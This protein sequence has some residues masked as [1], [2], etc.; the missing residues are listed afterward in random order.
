MPSE[1]QVS[2][3][4]PVFNAENFIDR[5][6]A[7][8][9]SQTEICW[10]LIAID[11]GSTDNSGHKLDTWAMKDARIKVYHQTNSG[12]AATRQKGV[13][14]A[15]GEY[16][17][18]VDA[19][20]WVEPDF[21]QVLLA[22]AKSTGADIVW[23]DCFTNESDQ[24]TMPCDPSPRAMIRA[25]LE[26]QMWGMLWNKLIRTSICQRQ[27]VVFPKDCSMW[28]DLA[29]LIQC[30]LH[31]ERMA[32]CPRPLYHYF[33]GNQNS[34]VT[35]Q[36]EKNISVEYQKAIDAIC[37]AMG[38]ENRL[39]EFEHELNEIKLFAIRNY[40]DDLRFRDFDRY[41]TL[42][43]EAIADISNH[44]EYPKRLHICTWLLQH[45][46]QFLVPCVWRIS[47]YVHKLFL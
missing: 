1:I 13:L 38:A 5:A 2:I 39:K 25:L 40:I 6:I 11:D 41:L 45:R 46:C 18:H 42:Y 8:I 33:L 43:P 21:L 12:V 16:T 37:V 4:M 7:S 31:T 30:L 28:E 47:L 26:Q 34:L 23:C 14:L 15:K 27:D 29:F 24:W 36:S 19:D 22:K 20:D 10:E 17:I 44:P 9:V 32:Y 35:R 3:V